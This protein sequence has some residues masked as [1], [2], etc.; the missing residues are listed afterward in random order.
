MVAVGHPRTHS[1]ET[2]YSGGNPQVLT[3]LL[4]PS[5]ATFSMLLRFRLLG[6]SAIGED[7]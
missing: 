5:G 2:T 3:L 6:A 7:F 4:T 1:V